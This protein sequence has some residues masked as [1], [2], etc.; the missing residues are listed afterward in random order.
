MR[1]L[2]V[3]LK[4]AE[5]APFV[6]PVAGLLNADAAP[7]PKAP[8]VAPP[9]SPP[10]AGAAAVAAGAPNRPPVAGCCRRRSFTFEFGRLRSFIIAHRYLIFLVPRQ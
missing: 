5:L 6:R 10:A 3:V 2:K 7:A 9:K 8:V 1:D 4:N